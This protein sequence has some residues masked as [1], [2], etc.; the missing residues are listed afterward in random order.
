MY[1]FCVFKLYVLRHEMESANKFCDTLKDILDKKCINSVYL[2]KS[3]YNELVSRV[4]A[5]K[6]K[7]RGKIP[8]EYKLLKR[9]DI[10]TVGDVHKL[11]YPINESS[12]TIKYYIHNDEIYNTIHEVHIS[13]S[14]GGRNRMQKELQ[15]KYKNITRESIMLY[16]N[17]CETC[18]RQSRSLK[19]EV[20]PKPIM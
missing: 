7:I 12:A 16:L 20:V 17:L 10:V 3:K 11:I 13:I 4:K 5:A 18:Q 1:H 9:Y 14:H 15:S 2:S 8:Q 19:K 6:T